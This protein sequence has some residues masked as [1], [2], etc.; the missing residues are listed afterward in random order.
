MTKIYIKPTTLVHQVK[1]ENLLQAASPGGIGEG[2]AWKSAEG[3]GF[4]FFMEEE[5]EVPGAEE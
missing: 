3:K 4:D 1:I 5:E 2:N